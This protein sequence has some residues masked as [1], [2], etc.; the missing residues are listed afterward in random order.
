[1]D[2]VSPVLTDLEVSSEQVVA[3][4]QE[5]Y[6]PIVVARI[7]FSNNSSCSLTRF[8]FSDRERALIAQG[9]DLLL[10]QPHHGMMMPVSVQLAMPGEYPVPEPESVPSPD[11]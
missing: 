7:R 1:M 8:R 5:G 3:L 6:Y 10:G 2:S 9:A 11:K 4:G